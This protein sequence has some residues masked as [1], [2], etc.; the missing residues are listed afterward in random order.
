MREFF[1]Q[2]HPWIMQALGGL[3]ALIAFIPIA[4]IVWIN[5]ISAPNST[6][7]TQTQGALA[8]P[9]ASTPGAPTVATGSGGAS[10]HPVWANVR[11][12][13]AANCAPCH[14]R[15]SPRLG[16]LD[17]TTYAG[18]LKGG[19]TAA[20]GPV[21]G[22]VIKP[23]DASGSYMYQV[24]TGKQQPQMPLGRTPLPAATI[25]VIFNWIQQ[26]AKQ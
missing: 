20:G 9:T 24:L 10:A 11:T 26:G 16:G 4:V 7:T 25:Q 3:I 15:N 13:F 6:P 12:I 14:I 1:R 19:S 21:N 17:L 18:A 8:S 22:A 23:G 5:V 2:S